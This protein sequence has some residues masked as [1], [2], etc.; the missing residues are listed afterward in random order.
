MGKNRKHI[1]ELR[2]RNQKKAREI[3]EMSGRLTEENH[4]GR[5]YSP[6]Y[7]KKVVAWRFFELW[8]KT[9]KYRDQPQELGRWFG[10]LRE[11]LQTLLLHWPDESLERGPEFW[12]VYEL[13]GL[14]RQGR[15]DD[16]VKKLTE[17]FGEI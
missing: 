3:R 7:A 12:L 9:R 10:R 1:E 4:N 16:L 2:S 15:M 6:E 8:M 5:D 17:T 14:W 13:L 11:G